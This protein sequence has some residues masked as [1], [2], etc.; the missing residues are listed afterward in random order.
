MNQ[1]TQEL[2]FNNIRKAVKALQPLFPDRT[3]LAIA[4]LALLGVKAKSRKPSGKV[5][6]EDVQ[7][8]F[9]KWGKFSTEDV[10]QELGVSKGSAA[11]LIAILRIKQILSPVGKDQA[12]S[13]VW[14]WAA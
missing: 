7:N 13:S 9:A 12:G 6:A 3:D 5:T 14:K 11:A 8:R 4:E 10:V 1:K 2:H